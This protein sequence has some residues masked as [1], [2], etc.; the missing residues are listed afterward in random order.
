MRLQLALSAR[1][2]AP[3]IAMARSRSPAARSAATTSAAPKTG[4]GQ[5]RQRAAPES[6]PRLAPIVAPALALAPQPRSHQH[7]NRCGAQLQGSLRVET[8][9]RPLAAG[10][11]ASMTRRLR[12]SSAVSRSGNPQE[13]RTGWLGACP[14]NHRRARQAWRLAQPASGT[15]RASK[16]LPRRCGTSRS[17]R[18]RGRASSHSWQLQGVRKAE[19]PR[20]LPPL[21]KHLWPSSDPPS[22]SVRAAAAEVM[23]TSTKTVAAMARQAPEIQSLGRAAAAPW[24]QTAIRSTR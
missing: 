23:T 19:R 18:S 8:Q 12:T 4:L 3:A 15:S 9:S 10:P 24:G 6:P 20:L 2:D 16:S 11:R 7:G 5:N 17:R 13:R 1:E 21:P 14:P 22:R